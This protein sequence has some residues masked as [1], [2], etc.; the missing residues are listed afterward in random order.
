MSGL[1]SLIVVSCMRQRQLKMI[2]ARL[3]HFVCLSFEHRVPLF[4]KVTRVLHFLSRL[5]LFLP[6]LDVLH[7]NLALLR[8]VVTI[9]WRLFLLQNQLWLSALGT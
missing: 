4:R 9:F 8:I 6:E 2:V 5:F 1:N 7:W 3:G